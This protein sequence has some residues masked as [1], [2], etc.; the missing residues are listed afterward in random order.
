M[1]ITS[2]LRTGLFVSDPG[3]EYRLGI[4]PPKTGQWQINS[5]S[6][7]R[8]LG[9]LLGKCYLE[10]VCV[11][12][13]FHRFIFKTLLG[14]GPSL[15]D[16]K[17]VDPELYKRLRDFERMKNIETLGLVFAVDEE[18]NAQKDE[19][20]VQNETNAQIQS[21]SQKS[22]LSEQQ[23]KIRT[24]ELVEGGNNIEV[25]E[26]NKFEYITLYVQ[27]KLVGRI[28]AQLHILRDGF[29]VLVPQNTLRQLKPEDLEEL[30]CGES[31]IDVD[32]WQ[33]NSKYDPPFSKNH[34]VIIWFWQIVKEMDDKQRRQLL[35]FSTGLGGVPSCGFG[36]I[37]D[38]FT[39]SKMNARTNHLPETHTCSFQLMMP[40]YKSKLQLKQKLLL[41]VSHYREGFGF[42]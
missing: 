1:E 10:N 35:Q 4:A 34:Q 28:S 18:V 13:R 2:P 40:E 6:V 30:I 16:L 41:A 23:Q 32:D 39:I 33:K 7:Y 15:H 38:K 5:M 14:Y 20:D 22:D 42:G 3:N 26:Q 12:V 17:N 19:K 9:V 24:I 37:Q 21:Q 27:N 36:Q 8:F 25:T 11:P 31:R 29:N